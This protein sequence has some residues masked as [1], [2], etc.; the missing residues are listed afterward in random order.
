[1]PAKKKVI[2]RPKAVLAA[3]PPR[4]P[5][6]GGLLPTAKSELSNLKMKLKVLQRIN[7]IAASTFDGHALLDRAM[8]LVTEIAPS[9]AGSLLLLSPSRAALRFTVVK[10][11]A[12]LKLEGTELPVGQGIA[13][14]VAKTGIPLI[15]N[16]VEHEPKWKRE[17]A[18]KIDYRTR[19]ILCVPLKNRSEVIGVI[20]LINKLRD[21]DYN[22]DDLE[23]IELLGGHLSTLIE[24]NRLYNEAR[25][26][27]ERISAMAQTSA[28]ISSSLSVKRVLE[29]VMQVAKDVIDAEASSIFMYS[30]EKHDFFFEVATGQAGDAVKEIRVPWGKGM[31]GWAAENMQTLLVPDVTQDP[32][33]YSK[34]DEKSKFQTRNAITVPLK[35]KDKLIGVA[36]VLNKK[37]GTFTPEDVELFE[38]L[39]RQAAVAIENASLYTDLEEMFRSSIRTVVSLIDAKDD[40]TAGHSSRVTKYALMIADQIGYSPEDRKRLELGAL[41]HDVGKIGMPD[42][43]LKKP[44]GL[45]DEEFTIVKNHPVKGAEALAPIKQMK[46][47][48][49]LVRGHH[50]RLDGRGYPDKLAGDAITPDAQIVCIADAYDAMNSDRPYRKGLGM[51]ESVA[52]L[53]KDAGT[54][55]NSKMVEAFVKG[56]EREAGQ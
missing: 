28:Q 9:E 3:P 17:I 47:I 39:S 54:Q 11:A 33:F 37:G 53:R 1:M 22:D 14:W 16:D 42:A 52:R 31:V 4:A 12:T 34:V 56:L 6:P 55:F 48:I 19:N 27:V 5:R 51:A 49:P 18:Q 44:S 45:T 7:E 15:V 32:R 36:Q 38:T 20:E 26:K 10:G 13:G 23:I 40:Y 43:I 46:E 8:D 50:E 41:L 30:E 21:E 2:A 25:E 29:N 24:N 35:P